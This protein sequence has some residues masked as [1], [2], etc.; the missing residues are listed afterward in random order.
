[1]KKIKSIFKILTLALIT[2]IVC[3]SSSLATVDNNG[4][5]LMLYNKGNGRSTGFYSVTT[6]GGAATKPVIKIVKTDSAGTKNEGYTESIYCIKDGIGFGSGTTESVVHY[7]NYFDLRNLDSID[8]TFKYNLPTGDNYTRLIWVLNNICVPSNDTSRKELLTKAGLD[9]SDFAGYKVS[10][11][12]DTD[13]RNDIIESI[14]QAAIWYYT[15]PSGEYHPTDSPVFY[16][17]SS[18]T[19]TPTSVSNLDSN[20]DI[21]DDP[22]QTLYSYLVNGAKTGTAANYNLSFTKSEAKL[23][24]SGSNYLV[25]PYKL[26]GNADLI[27]SA[28]IKDNDGNVISNAKIIVNGA[29]ASGSTIKDQ[30]KVSDGKEF[31]IQ[32]PMTTSATSIKIDVNYSTKTLTYWSADA[33]KV[34][35]TQPVVIVKSESKSFSD[36]QNIETPEFDLALRKFI[37]SINGVAPTTSRVPSI[38][39]TDLKA[40]ADE[41]T[42]K[43]VDGKGQ[44]TYKKHTK[45]P[46]SVNAGDKV[47]YTIRIYNEGNLDGKATEIADYLPK[48]LKLSANSTINTKYGWTA[49]ATNSQKITTTYLSSTNLKAFNATPA[50]GTYTISTA[51][52]MVECDVDSSVTPSTHLKNV[53]EIT[54]SENSLGL[55]DRDSTTDNVTEK[56][57]KYSTSTSTKGKGYEDDDDYEELLV[58]DQE[59]DLALRK[60]IVSVNGEATK[61]SREPVISQDNLRALA[62]KDTKNTFDGTTTFKTHTKDP[63]KVKTGDKVLYT[64]RVYNEGEVDGKATEIVDYLPEG[65]KLLTN[66][67]INTKYGWKASTNNSQEVRTTYLKDT[68]LTAFSNKAVN[69]KYTI[70]YADIQVECEVVAS[71]IKTTSLKNVAEI[72]KSENALGLKDR[73]STTDNVTEKGEKYSISTSTKGKGYEDDDD[74]EELLLQRFDLALRKFITGVNDE[75]I[76][77]RE[78]VVD[79]SKFGTLVD[80]KEVTTCTY[81][82]TKETVRV[83]HDDTVYYTI[84]VY[85]EGNQEGYAS[86]VKDDLPEGIQFLPDNQTNKDYRWVMYDKD[87]KVT[88]DVTKAD[89]IQT[90]YLSKEQ[91]K[92]TGANLLKAFD[93]DTMDSPDYRDVVIAF[94]VTEPNTS[95]RIIINK[96]QVKKHTD[97]DGEDVTDIDSTPDKWIEGEDDQDIEKIY[98]KYFDLALRKWVTQA[99]VI[100]DGQE[101]VMDTG[102]KPEDEPESVVKVEVNKKR[103]NNTVIKFRYSIRITN[104]G[105]IAGHALEISDYIPKG[106][107]FNQADNPQWKEVDGKIVTD[108]LKDTLLQPGSHADVEVLLTWVNSEDNMGVMVNT[109]EISEDDNDD[110]DS[111]PNNKKEGEDDIDT[112]PVALTVVTGKAQ[113]FIAITSVVLLIVGSGVFFIKKFVI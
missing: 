113:T 57:E 47:I 71:G 31:Y 55:K 43:T 80:G 100:E 32:V 67:E 37:V 64:I 73:D 61:V 95:D 72:T 92:T 13:V 4:P 103:M 109:A 24:I 28:T 23:S 86:I 42:T 104:E 33:N 83:E 65:L 2:F 88:T 52:V 107:K 30:L 68:N 54:K 59:F 41:D 25:G 75:K 69:G 108:Q 58:K 91:E 82:H 90:D 50:N 15:N 36:T 14:Q 10:G 1:M 3:Q 45:T 93:V 101:K 62:N 112:A 29:Q 98:V 87:G 12:T 110:I 35:V 84:R 8:S 11:K 39:D 19:G 111:T 22:V 106:L 53:A 38:T 44:T 20:A 74:Y 70:S 49:D 46:L 99:I 81:N 27:S 16:Y 102:H 9:D 7:T 17:S 77:N 94:K 76:T 18:N 105:E 21:V 51:D 66:S 89:Y 78:P 63:V 34:A 79:K 85:N 40:L 96:A 5:Y 26:T 60:F 48:G 56:G 97:K 6:N